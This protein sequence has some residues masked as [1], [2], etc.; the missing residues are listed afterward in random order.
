LGRG[1]FFSALCVTNQ[2]AE[3]FAVSDFSAVFFAHLETG[4]STSRR[5]LM[6]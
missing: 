6:P 4:L 2:T 1:H 5:H 3:N